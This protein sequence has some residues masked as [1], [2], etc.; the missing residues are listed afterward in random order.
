VGQHHLV[1][2]PAHARFLVAAERGVPGRVVAVG[3]HAAGLDGA[4]HA[5]R[6]VAVA[7]PHAGAQAVEGVIGQ[8][9]GFFL[10]LKVVTASTG[11]KISSWKM[12]ILLW[13]LKIVGCT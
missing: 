4:A 5:V 2:L 11:P 6:H 7:A 3:P 13:P 8:G 1:V 10:V 12:R 9:Q